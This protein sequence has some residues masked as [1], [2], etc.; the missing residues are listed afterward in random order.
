[1]NHENE[2]KAK[3][4]VSDWHWL[5][6]MIKIIC[7]PN[8]LALSLVVTEKMNY[9]ENFDWVSEPW[10]WG[11][12]HVAYVRLTWAASDKW[13]DQIMDLSRKLWRKVNAAVAGKV[14]PMSR[15][16]DKFCD[17]VAG[18]TKIVQSYP[19]QI[20][21]QS[22]SH[23]QLIHKQQPSSY[24]NNIHIVIPSS[25]TNKNHAVITGLY[26]NNIKSHNQLIYE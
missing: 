17:F 8:M 18:K 10:K 24:V 2:V 25:Y 5:P 21:P 7:R 16:H 19:A 20:K 4:H 12:A 22:Y 26:I 14:I 15:F 1:M 23:T 11:Q 3:W 6:I 13:M 9:S